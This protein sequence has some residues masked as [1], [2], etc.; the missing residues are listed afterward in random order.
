VPIE[1]LAVT[2]WRLRDPGGR[3][4]TCIVAGRGERWDV[5]VRRGRE[6]LIAERH[7]TDDAALGRANEIWQTYRELGWTE[8]RH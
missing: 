8:P 2:V 6:L 1:R 5:L 3:P 4:A 7:F